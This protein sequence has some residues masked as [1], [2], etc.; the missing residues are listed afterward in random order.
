MKIPTSATR[1]RPKTIDKD[2]VLHAAM[3]QYWTHG[4]LNVSIND[5]CKC[6]NTSKPAIYREFGNDDGLKQAA[7]QSYDM[8]AVQPFLR[9][10]NPEQD[11]ENT[12]HCVVNFMIGDREAE[13]LPKGCLFVTMRAQRNALGP[14]AQ[15]LLDELRDGF[16]SKI[17]L[18]VC[19]GQMEG[20]ISADI[21][22]KTAAHHIDA[23]HAGAMRMQ[24]E[25]ENEEEIKRFL[26]LGFNCISTKKPFNFVH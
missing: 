3:M 11:F 24:K 21:H 13:G 12:I 6:V 20:N 16:L 18:W 2:Q 4:P 1:G 19:Q 25:G 23:L 8:L 5:I 9:L 17:E 15:A 26:V 7:L 22:P 10:F 14:A